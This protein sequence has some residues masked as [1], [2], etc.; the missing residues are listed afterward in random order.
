MYAWPV[1]NF[2]DYTY[3]FGVDTIF[4]LL[5]VVTAF[6]IF[7]LITTIALGRRPRWNV[8]DALLFGISF[9]AVFLSDYS[10]SLVSSFSHIHNYLPTTLLPLLFASVL[11]IRSNTAV[12]CF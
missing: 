6:A 9:L 12:A 1:I 10:R 8:Q 2:F 5:D 4:R 11:R 7:F 3:K